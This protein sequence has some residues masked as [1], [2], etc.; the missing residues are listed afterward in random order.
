MPAVSQGPIDL[1]GSVWRDVDGQPAGFASDGPDRARRHRVEDSDGGVDLG[2][3]HPH[4]DGA[5]ALEQIGDAALA[6]DAPGRDDPEDVDQLLDLAEDMARH[7]HGLARC[8]EL[9]E[10][11]AHG[12]DAR[13]VEPVR[14]LVKEQ[15]ARVTEQ[16]GGDAE[17]LLHPERIGLDAVLGPLAQADEL[18]ELLDPRLRRP[19]PGRRQGAKV[20]SRR[21]VGV[22]RRRLDERTDIEQAA[23]IAASERPPENLDRARIG[24]DEPGEQPHRGRLA[25]AIRAQEPVDHPGRDGQVEPGEG[26]PRAVA[27]LQAARRERESVGS[28]HGCPLGGPPATVTRRADRHAIAGRPLPGASDDTS[29]RASATSPA[30]PPQGPRQGRRRA[31]STRCSHSRVIHGVDS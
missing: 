14:W 30:G 24:M 28:G 21:Q 20:L 8:R 22:E 4:S 17:T 13:R 15:Q 2:W 16:G 9:P 27:L 26:R 23:S 7:E 18:E 19:G 12:D 25:R 6:H 3:R 31:S 11:R 5:F 10:R 1:G 29:D